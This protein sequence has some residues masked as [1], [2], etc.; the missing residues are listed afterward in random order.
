MAVTRREPLGDDA[1]EDEPEEPGFG[2]YIAIEQADIRLITADLSFAF[3]L[4]R[5]CADL[6]P[7]RATIC[8]VADAL[9]KLRAGNATYD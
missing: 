8:I 5:Q 6:E 3:D 2:V 9:A 7:E 1:Y 4:C